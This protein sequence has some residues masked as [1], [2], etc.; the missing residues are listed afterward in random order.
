MKNCR[1]HED[2]TVTLADADVALEALAGA[3]GQG[4]EI[5]RKPQKRK[6]KTTLIADDGCLLKNPEAA[7]N[8]GSNKAVQGSGQL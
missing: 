5:E 2:K 7:Q 6:V 3:I 4:K 1:G 8:T